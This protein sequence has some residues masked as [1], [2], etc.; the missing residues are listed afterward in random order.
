MF[1]LSRRVLLL[2][3][4]VIAMSL[5][6]N[7]HAWEW[8][9]GGKSI[10]GSGVVKTEARQVSGFTGIGLSL[11]AKVTVR[12]GTKEAITIEADDN[13]LPLIETVVERGSLKIRTT[14]KNISF[15]G[16]SATLN[17]IVD[18]INVDHLSIAGSGD[19]VSDALKADKL[20]AS[21]AG[22]GDL[23]LKALTVVRFP[24]VPTQLSLVA[25][26]PI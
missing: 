2:I 11:P 24:S 22:S 13:F 4:F 9:W 26:S 25:I 1:T 19:M 5:A 16:K 23:K 7:A 3:T 8:S 6:P 10:T 15:K 14:E 17:I 12:Q 18:I 20:K 21:V